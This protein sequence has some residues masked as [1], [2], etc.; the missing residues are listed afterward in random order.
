MQIRLFIKVTQTRS[1]LVPLALYAFTTQVNIT[2]NAFLSNSEH[3]D[4][5]SMDDVKPLLKARII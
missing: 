1:E 4:L 3:D 2:K 5:P